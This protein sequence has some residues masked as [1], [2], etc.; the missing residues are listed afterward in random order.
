[1]TKFWLS[2]KK[3]TIHGLEADELEFASTLVAVNG[4]KFTKGTSDF[5]GVTRL[6]L[7]N[8]QH[9]YT[10][11]YKKDQIVLHHTVGFLSGDAATLTRDK[12]STA[13][14]LGRTGFVGE[15]FNPRYY[16]YHLG[17]NVVGGNKIRSQRT[18]AIELSNFGPLKEHATNPDILV[19]MWDFPYCMK[20][21]TEYYVECPYRGHK[22]YATYTD[23]QMKALDSL[24][25]KLCRE[26]NI[27]HTF[28][29]P[30]ERM[31]VQTKV[32]SAGIVS[33]VNYR[34]DKTDVSPAFDYFK[35]SG[36]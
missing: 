31:K 11:K 5:D 33:H 2:K 34:K 19:D 12:V 22:Y 14:L 16:A 24:L 23:A 36:R 27:P 13:Y 9:Y 17:P 35:I 30:N 3:L 10:A 7:E 21:D 32:P 26:F 1:M 6:N 15:L 4:K 29:P 28:L 8:P 18:I 25:L 20:S